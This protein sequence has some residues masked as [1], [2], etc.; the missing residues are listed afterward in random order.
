MKSIKNEILTKV[1]PKPLRSSKG[2]GSTQLVELIRFEFTSRS[3]KN[4]QY[5]LRSFA[6]FLGVSHTLLSLVMSGKRSPSKKLILKISDKLILD[7]EQKRNLLRETQLEQLK[8][9]KKTNIDLNQNKISLDTFALISEWQH[10]AIL[11]LL[12]IADTELTPEFIAKRL[13]ISELVA[14]IS[15]KRLFDLN[16]IEKNQKT[17]RWQQSSQPIVVENTE[18]T[19]YTRKFQKQ[20]LEKAIESLES[21]PIEK[22]DVSSI[23]FAFDPAHI[24]YALKRIRQFRRELTEEL[25]SFGNPQEVYN[26]TVQIFPTSKRNTK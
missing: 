13:N 2:L 5:S 26:L 11:S 6:K 1:E 22:R 15:L 8:K 7:P 4:P 19:S 10:Y 16:L 18:S 24:P 23:T 3:Q 14:R 21:D 12:E 25:E 20:L 9:T 17:G